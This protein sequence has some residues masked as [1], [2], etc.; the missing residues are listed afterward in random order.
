MAKKNNHVVI[1]CEYGWI[2]CGIVD[3]RNDDIITMSDSAVVRKWSNGKGIGAI[4]R[5][6]NRDEY[7]LDE[8]GK[9]EIRQN[10]VLFEIP[11]EW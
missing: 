7:T 1:V 9:V 8:I 10:K 11:C 3:K 4:S 6:E 5:A 2:I